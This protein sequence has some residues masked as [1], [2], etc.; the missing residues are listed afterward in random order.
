[1]D[2]TL[3]DNDADATEYE[4]RD[5]RGRLR[6]DE[7]LTVKF[8]SAPVKSKPRSD[9]EGRPI[10]QDLTF[11]SIK[12]PGDQYCVIETIATEAYFKRFPLDYQRFTEGQTNHAHGTPLAELP[13][14]AASQIKEL[15]G[16]D[17]QTIEVLAELGDE[18]TKRYTGMATLKAKA[19]D[20]L[21]RVNDSGFA[22]KQQAELAK[23]DE[24]IAALQAQVAEIL[25]ASSTEKTTKVSTK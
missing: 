8:A 7:R 25:K 22:V 17:I 20:Y 19:G 21:K 3:F 9:E 6:G 2:A 5:A 10:Y 13:G 18:L 11:I 12:T 14:L 15:H 16:I 1:M 4:A 23:R 24:Q